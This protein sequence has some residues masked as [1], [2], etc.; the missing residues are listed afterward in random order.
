MGTTDAK[1]PGTKMKVANPPNKNGN[2]AEWQN[3]GNVFLD[4]TGRRGTFY[5]DISVEQLNQLLAGATDGRA[6]KK[7]TIFAA[8]PRE[9][10]QVA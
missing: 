7:I 6:K 1:K 4:P 5:L 3:F 2:G 10:A 9:R 8:P